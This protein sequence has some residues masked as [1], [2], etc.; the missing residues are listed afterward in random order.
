LKLVNCAP[1]LV[2]ILGLPE[3][4]FFARQV[5]CA[6]ADAIGRNGGVP[7]FPIVKSTDASILQ[8]VVRR[9]SAASQLVRK[10]ENTCGIKDVHGGAEPAKTVR[11]V[12][13]GT[14]G[15]E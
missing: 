13:A 3:V 5:S 11:R 2:P 9:A 8:P 6:A 10:L 1:I 4:G 15:R 7:L 14:Q 12:H